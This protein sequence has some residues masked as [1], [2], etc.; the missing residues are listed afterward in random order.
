MKYVVTLDP[1]ATLSLI[2]TSIITLLIMSV[3]QQLFNYNNKIHQ[4]EQKCILQIIM[5]LIL[6]TLLKIETFTALV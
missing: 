4:A 6:E 3:N 1:Y 2:E 5:T